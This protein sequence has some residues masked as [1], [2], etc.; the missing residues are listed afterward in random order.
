MSQD[1]SLLQNW[2]TWNSALF[3]PVDGPTMRSFLVATALLACSSLQALYVGS[4]A[5]PSV[6]DKGFFIPENFWLS[7]E[8]GYQG[9]LVLNRNLKAY[10]PLSA[11]VEGCYMQMDQGVMTLGILNRVQFY[12]SIGSSKISLSL[13]PRSGLPTEVH[14]TSRNQLTWGAGLRALLFSWGDLG[15]GANVCYQHMNPSIKSISNF[16]LIAFPEGT[17]RYTEWQGAAGFNYSVDIFN[18]YIA[19][20]YSYV[21]AAVHSSNQI[22]PLLQLKARQRLGMALGCALSSSKIFDL[23][24]EVRLFGQRAI[25]AAGNIRF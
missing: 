14:L 20:T 11:S 21:H 9:D 6:I 3:C 15:F 1:R 10:G 19:I 13:A 18:P 24:L 23:T 4:P 16:V 22:L 7:V 25:S 17:I 5:E 2:L 12:G 8:A